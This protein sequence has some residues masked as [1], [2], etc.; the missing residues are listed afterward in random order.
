MLSESR[1]QDVAKLVIVFHR[2]NLRY[3]SESLECF[4]V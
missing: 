3:G 2:P 1:A 4:V